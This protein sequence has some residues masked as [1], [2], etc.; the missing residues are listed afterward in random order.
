LYLSPSNFQKGLLPA[1]DVGKSVSRVGGKAQLKAFKQI[2][3]RIGVEYSQFEELEMFSKFATKLDDETQKIIN[4]GKL[5]RETLKQDRFKTVSTEG[6]IAIFMCIN[7]G[8]LDGIELERI[9]E[10]QNKIVTLASTCF[11]DICNTIRKNEKLSKEQIDA[12][13][14]EAKKLI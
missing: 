5:I 7:N 3:G 2:A 9:T 14:E 6:Q 8:L 10:I 12:F 1:I 13:L 11:K 4:R